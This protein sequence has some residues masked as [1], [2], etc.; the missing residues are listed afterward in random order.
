M[1]AKSDWRFGIRTAGSMVAGLVLAYRWPWPMDNA[2]LE[3]IR[4]ERMWLYSAIKYAYMGMLFTTPCIVISVLFS[5]A[6]IFL[7]RPGRTRPLAKLPPYPDPL[8]R[9]ELSLVIGELRERSANPLLVVDDEKAMAH[10][11]FL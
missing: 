10:G 11:T 4:L 1:T 2:L 5:L 8:M 9:Q 3:L 6:S 7:E